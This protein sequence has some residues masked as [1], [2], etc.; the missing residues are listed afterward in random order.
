MSGALKKRSRPSESN[1]FYDVVI[2]KEMVPTKFFHEMTLEDLGLLNCTEAMLAHAG[3]GN[4]LYLAAP[5]H[6]NMTVEFLTT[7]W[8]WPEEGF[9]E[10]IEFSYRKRKY[11]MTADQLRGALGITAPPSPNWNP[12]AITYLHHKW[13]GDVTGRGFRG[14]KE[15]NYFFTHPPLH[16]AHKVL[17]MSFFGHGEVNKVS[18]EDLKYL[19][20]LSQ[21]CE[22]IPDWAGAF[23]ASCH[24][25]R[26]ADKGKISMG[27]MVTLIIQA[28]L[29][30]LSALS[31]PG[32]KDP[33]L[34]GYVYDATWLRTNDYLFP[35]EEGYMWESGQHREH[36]ISLPREFIYGPTETFRVVPDDAVE[37]AG[38]GLAR[39]PP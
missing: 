13:W 12:K 7:L 11:V 17:A 26:T 2:A 10:R 22:I 15:Y 28:L 33:P 1:Q 29:D 27:G 6:A 31:Q 9:L 14:G 24:K 23:I 8:F 19:M 25:A 30:D 36:I 16:L 20:T 34:K 38:P 32:T 3:L 37:L 35:A 39:P 18:A 21:E 4:F 5:T